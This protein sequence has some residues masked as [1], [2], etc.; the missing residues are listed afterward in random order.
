[1][2]CCAIGSLVVL[3]VLK[4]ISYFIKKLSFVEFEENS[5]FVINIEFNLHYSKFG[6]YSRYFLL[7]EVK[8]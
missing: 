8:L 7:H 4:R 3:V 2:F 1:M 6:V 5:S